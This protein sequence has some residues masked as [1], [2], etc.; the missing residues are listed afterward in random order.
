MTNQPW[1]AVYNA[2]ISRMDEEFVD[3]HFVPFTL[4]HAEFS[5]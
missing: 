1:L 3:E 4:E 2:L 5:S